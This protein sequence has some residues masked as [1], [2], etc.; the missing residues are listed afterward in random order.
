MTPAARFQVWPPLDRTDPAVSAGH[1]AAMWR[2]VDCDRNFQCV[3]AHRNRD[4]AVE[5]AASLN[6]TLQSVERRA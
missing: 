2:V 1:P 6:M 5:A 3:A 4:D